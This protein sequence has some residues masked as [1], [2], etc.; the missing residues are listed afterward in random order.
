MCNACRMPI[1]LITLQQSLLEHKEGE[2]ENGAAGTLTPSARSVGNI[3]LTFAASSQQKGQ[4]TCLMK[5]TRA[6]PSPTSP[7]RETSSPVEVSRVRSPLVMSLE[8]SLLSPVVWKD[9][10]AWSGSDAESLRP[11]RTA[12]LWLLL[13][14]C[15]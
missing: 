12:L 6:L 7:E 14:P 1:R 3:L 8:I 11:P 10:H 5:T 2:R 4:P 9:F 13:L 15:P